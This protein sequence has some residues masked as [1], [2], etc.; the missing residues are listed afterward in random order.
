MEWA[1]WYGLTNLDPH[2]VALHNRYR[3]G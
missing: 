3:R 1:R 2:A